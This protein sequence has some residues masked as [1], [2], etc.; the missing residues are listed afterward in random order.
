MQ[1]R[2]PRDSGNHASQQAARS[3]NHA[4]GGGGGGG[5]VGGMIA[6]MS[7]LPDILVSR[8]REVSE[9]AV[10]SFLNPRFP[11]ARFPVS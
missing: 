10:L 4:V 7:S 9:Y 11:N 3:G 1:F 2:K 8:I 6:F 5:G